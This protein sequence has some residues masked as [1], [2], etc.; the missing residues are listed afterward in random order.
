MEAVPRHL[1]L[2]HHRFGWQ[3]AAFE[4]DGREPARL[5]RAPGCHVVSI[6]GGN[7]IPAAAIASLR[8]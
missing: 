2:K 3:M 6:E 4:I 7:V 8:H 5:K 1:H